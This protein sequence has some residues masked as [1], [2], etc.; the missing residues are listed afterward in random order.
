VASKEIR[1]LIQN[2]VQQVKEGAQSVSTAGTTMDE[3]VQSVKHVASIVDEIAV[4]SVEQS[5]GIGQVNTAVTQMDTATH[6][7]AALVE[8]ATAAVI[9]LK[10]QADGMRTLVAQFRLQ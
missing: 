9:S 6:Q 5:K 8:Q 10:D 7:N 3:I 1:D 2:S 4:A